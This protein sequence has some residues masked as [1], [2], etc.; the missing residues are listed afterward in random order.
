MLW[1]QFK[2]IEKGIERLSG[3]I[4]CVR[5]RSYYPKIQRDCH[6]CAHLSDEELP[7]LLTERKSFRISLGKIMFGGAILI[8]ILLLVVSD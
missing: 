4:C 2:R 1:L 5:C 8:L 7:S 3:Q 6:H